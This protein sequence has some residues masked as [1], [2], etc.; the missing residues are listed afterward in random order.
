M[1]PVNWGVIGDADIA[2]VKV[3]PGMQSGQYCNV[4]GLASRNGDKAKATAAK[5]GNVSQHGCVDA[6][7]RNDQD[8]VAESKRTAPSR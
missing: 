6:E 7:A 5:L 8:H 3:I 1:Q 4:M 2:R